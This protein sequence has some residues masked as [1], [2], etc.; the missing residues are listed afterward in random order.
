M[1]LLALFSPD[2][3]ELEKYARKTNLIISRQNV[4]RKNGRA[5]KRH[6][7]KPAASLR[8]AS[9]S[10]LPEISYPGQSASE[11]YTY[12]LYQTVVL[13]LWFSTFLEPW[14]ILCYLKVCMAIALW[15]TAVRP[16]LCGHPPRK[17]KVS[18]FEGSA[19]FAQ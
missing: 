16:Q 2:C 17:K 7:V 15:T 3:T 14:P 18:T 4:L 12:H 13:G 19:L 11:Y 8:L 10:H 1:L 5:S 6:E 9:K